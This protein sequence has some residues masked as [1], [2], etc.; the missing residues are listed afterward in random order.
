MVWPSSSFSGWRQP[1]RAV[2]CV[3]VGWLEVAELACLVAHAGFCVHHWPPLSRR[4]LPSRSYCN[5]ALMSCIR[6]LSSALSECICPCKTSI[7]RHSVFWYGRVR[8]GMVWYGM[9]WNGMVWYG[10]VVTCRERQVR[11]PLYLALSAMA[12]VPRQ[13]AAIFLWL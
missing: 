11:Q 8:Y 13:S 9:V 6:F 12:V 1:C 5:I 4:E 3:Q 7:L 2:T 10:M